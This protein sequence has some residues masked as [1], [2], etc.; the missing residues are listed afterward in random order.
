MEFFTTGSYI[1]ASENGVEKGYVL[2]NKAMC[3]VE[4][5][6]VYKKF[7]CQGIGSKLLKKVEEDMC[8]EKWL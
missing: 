5:L 2:Y 1:E 3:K 7:Q 4:E 8:E 6:V